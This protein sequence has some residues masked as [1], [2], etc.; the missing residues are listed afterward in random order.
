MRSPQTIGVECPLPDRAVFQ[1]MCLVSLHSSG[2]CACGATP[3]PSGPR[4]W[5][6]EC[7]ASTGARSVSGSPASRHVITSLPT[8][9]SM[10]IPFQLL[11]R[12]DRVILGRFYTPYC[13]TWDLATGKELSTLKDIIAACLAFH[14]TGKC[15]QLRGRCSLVFRPT[16]G[17][18]EVELVVPQRDGADQRALIVVLRRHGFLHLVP[19]DARPHRVSDLPPR[20][21]SAA[22][23]D[24][25]R[26]HGHADGL[27]DPVNAVFDFGTRRRSPALD[28]DEVDPAVK[29][30]AV[31]IHRPGNRGPLWPLTAASCQRQQPHGQATVQSFAHRK[32]H[33]HIVLWSGRPP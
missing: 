19:P 14:P 9:T 3:V 29:G 20:R 4:H 21:A 31:H 2:G 17:Q 24:A 8:S 30:P 6:Q 12:T 13:K 15:L 18:V 25:V 11:P 28:W 16:A 7:C 27:V 26:P 23:L 5:G 33:L 10:R 22:D 1:R 32:R